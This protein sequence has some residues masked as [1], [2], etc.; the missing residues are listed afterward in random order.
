MRD[1]SLRDFLHFILIQTEDQRNE[2]FS[3]LLSKQKNNGKI[4]NDFQPKFLDFKA[5]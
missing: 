4:F 2:L 3:T 5:E 1:V